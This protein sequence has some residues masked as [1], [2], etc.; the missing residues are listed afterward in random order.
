MVNGIALNA[1]VLDFIF[2][3]IIQGE[4]L[5]I[6]N[7]VTIILLL[8]LVVIVVVVIVIHYKLLF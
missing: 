5:T 6:V 3:I 2:V 8:I 1:F 7:Y 4:I